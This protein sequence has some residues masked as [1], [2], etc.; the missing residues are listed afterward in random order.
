MEVFDQSL[1]TPNDRFFVRWRWA[2]IP[3]TVDV[4]SFRLAV[5]GHVNRSLS[6][7]LDDLLALPRMELAAINQCS[8]NSRGYFQ[9]RVP[10]G[11]CS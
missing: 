6:L 4:N 9:P 7:S 3:S 10:G 2:V 8:A 11:E 1:F 5:H